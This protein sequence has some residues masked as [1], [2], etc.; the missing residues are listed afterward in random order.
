LA[1]WW[2]QSQ[3]WIAARFAA[4]QAFEVVQGALESLAAMVDALLFA[5]EVLTPY[6]QPEASGTTQDEEYD[7]QRFSVPGDTLRMTGDVLV[8]LIGLTTAANTNAKTVRVRFN[9]ADIFAISGTT[10]NNASYHFEVR[11]KRVT[12]STALCSVALLRNGASVGVQRNVL[13]ELDFTSTIELKTRSVNTA[14]AAASA[15]SETMIVTRYP[16]RPAS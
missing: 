6:L 2:S 1:N 7:L 9:N 15:T 12:S 8:A 3:E 16:A 14:A 13:T 10:D 11:I 5:P 4:V